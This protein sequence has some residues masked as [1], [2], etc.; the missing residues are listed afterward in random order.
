MNLTK[1]K[2]ITFGAVLLVCLTGFAG[3]NVVT[4][5]A[6]AT[7]YE[8]SAIS[9]GKI[10]LSPSPGDIIHIT[11][12]SSVNSC[13][14]AVLD[15]ATHVATV[16]IPQM[17]EGKY[18]TYD[19]YVIGATNGGHC[20]LELHTNQNWPTGRLTDCFYQHTDPIYVTNG[21]VVSFTAT[22]DDTDGESYYLDYEKV[23]YVTPG[24]GL[25]LDSQGNLN[26]TGS[27][28]GGS[29]IYID[30]ATHYDF[31]EDG[32]TDYNGR[33]TLSVTSPEQSHT[34]TYSA[35]GGTGSV[36][37][38]VVTDTNNGNTNVTLAANG[39]TKA[40]YTF[41]GWKVGNTTY[42]PGQSVP[43][44]AN[45]TVTA[46]AQ[47]SQNTLSAS[48][49]N[50]SCVSKLTYTNQIGASANN[51]ADL[52]FSVKSCTGGTATVNASGLVTYK[53]PTVTSTSSYTVTVTVTATFGDGQTMS[54]DVSFS[55]SVD[56][57][58]SFT[59][60]ATSGTLSVKGA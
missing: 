4:E 2:T 1:N 45:A 29:T 60:A 27:A 11:D 12:V 14:Y 15:T 28:Q 59:N 44:G 16:T 10:D 5:N 18:S 52:S 54:K 19:S 49:N 46:T 8:Y 33:L 25:T 17:S 41:I 50:L 43:V 20:W 34:V 36:S 21:T 47:W 7:L 35:N 42:Q 48:A 30:W 3:L 9:A 26:G 37:N 6:D 22:Y 13:P 32:I 57:V 24:M 38:T 31:V 39:F 53:A 58:L 23:T 55:V 51:G 56:P 40:G